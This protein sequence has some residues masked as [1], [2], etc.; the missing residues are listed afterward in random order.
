MLGNDDTNTNKAAYLQLRSLLST[1]SRQLHILN[2]LVS[3]NK[4]WSVLKIITPITAKSLFLKN[5]CIFQNNL[6]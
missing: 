6:E 1:R 2:T 3:Y 4:L 5:I